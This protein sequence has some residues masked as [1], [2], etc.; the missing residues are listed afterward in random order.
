MALF[1]AVKNTFGL[2]IFLGERKMFKSKNG[3]KIFFGFV[4]AFVITA[5]L[6]VGLSFARSKQPSFAALDPDIEY[7]LQAEE[8]FLNI[9]N[10]VLKGL[11]EAGEQEVAGRHYW[12]VVPS[13]VTSIEG[14][15]EASYFDDKLV[16][17]T[18]SSLTSIGDYAFYN[19][20]SLKEA[21]REGGNLKTIGK[22]AFAGCRSLTTFSIYAS[23][24]VG[25]YAFA[26]CE[27]LTRV[28]F[29]VGLNIKS[30]GNYA[31][32]GCTSL[33]FIELPDSVTSVGEGTFTNCTSLQ[34]AMFTPTD[35]DTFSLGT[36][37]FEG[38]SSLEAIVFGYPT[39]GSEKY[40][41]VKANL[42]KYNLTEYE[43]KITHPVRLEYYERNLADNRLK[44]NASIELKLNNRDIYWVYG[45]YGNLYGGWIKKPDYTLLNA[46]EKGNSYLNSTWS[47]KGQN[48]S[49]TIDQ[50]SQMLINGVSADEDGLYKLKLDEKKSIYYFKDQVTLDWTE[51]DFT[52]QE[53]VAPDPHS[54]NFMTTS[55]YEI[56]L[57]DLPNRY[58]GQPV[59]THITKAGHFYW[60]YFAKEKGSFAADSYFYIE[61][62]IKPADLKN[63]KVEFVNPEDA[64]VTF[65]GR[66]NSVPLKLTY[67]AKTVLGSEEDIPKYTL[68]SEDYLAVFPE[69]D[70]CMPGRKTIKI[71]GQSNGNFIGETELEYT[72]I[73]CELGTEEGQSVLEVS[74]D[75]VYYYTGSYIEPT[76]KNILLRFPYTSYTADIS[77]FNVSYAQYGKPLNAG[78]TKIRLEANPLNNTFC[79]GHFDVEFEVR[80]VSLRSTSI[81]KGEVESFTYDG[82][83]HKP[84]PDIYLDDYQLTAGRDFEYV[85]EGQDFSAAGT[86]SIEIQAKSSNFLDNTFVYFTINKRDI[87]EDLKLSFNQEQES[88]DF[89]SRQITP[90]ISEIYML[91]DGGEHLTLTKGSDCSISFG[92]NIH[93]STGGTITISA[94]ENG[95]YEGTY[96]YSFAI[97]AIDMESVTVEMTGSEEYIYDGLEHSPKFNLKIGSYTVPTA[98]YNLSAVGGSSINV[99]PHPYI[100]DYSYN[101]EDDITGVKNITITI[102]PR[103]ISNK[104]HVEKATITLKDDNLVYTGHAI[105]P[106][107]E[108]VELKLYGSIVPYLTMNEK[109]FTVSYGENIKAG[110]Y[111]EVTIKGT[112]NYTGEY[113]DSFFIDRKDINS[114]DVIITQTDITYDG[115]AHV[116]HPQ[117]SLNDVPFVEDVDYTIECSEKVDAGVY[118]Y[119]IKGG[120]KNGDLG[121]LDNSK[122]LTFEVVQRDIGAGGI[123]VQYV[124][125]E[126]QEYKGYEMQPEMIITIYVDETN[127]ITLNKGT[128]YSVAYD[129]N[130]NVGQASVTITGEGTNFT[131]TAQSHFTITPGTIENA[132]ISMEE[133]SYDGKQ[134][135]I[136]PEVYVGK[137]LLQKDVN[138]TISYEDDMTN[139]GVKNITFT[140]IT[141]DGSNF[142]ESQA[143]RQFKINPFSLSTYGAV[144][145]YLEGGTSFEYTGE[146]ILPTVLRVVAHLGGDDVVI[147][148]QDYKVEYDINVTVGANSV[149]IVGKYDYQSAVTYNCNYVGTYYQTFNITKRN[150]SSG[151]RVTLDSTSYTFTGEQICP[152]ITSF[153]ALDG[154]HLKLDGEKDY[155]LSYGANKDAGRGTVEIRST[156]NGSLTGS[157]TVEFTIE[158]ISVNDLEISELED[159]TYDGYDHKPDDLTVRIGSNTLRKGRDY[160]LNY[161]NDD[162]F[163]CGQKSV[164]VRG[165]SGNITG[166]KTLTFTINKV[167]IEDAVVVELNFEGGSYLAYTGSQVAP[168]VLYISVSLN[169]TRYITFYESEYDVSY[170]E[171]LNVGPATF[172]ITAKP[173]ANF[174]GSYTKELTIYMAN[175][176]LTGNFYIPDFRS[177]EN[178]AE[179]VPVPKFGQATITYDDFD[180]H[181]Y[182][183]SQLRNAN[184]G[185]YRATVRVEGTSNYTEY[186]NTFEFNILD[187]NGNMPG[188][189]GQG[190]NQG[191]GGQGGNQGG[192]QGDN[193]NY[194]GDHHNGGGDNGG[195]IAV[196]VG[197][198]GVITIAGVVTSV[199]LVKKK[200]KKLQK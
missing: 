93:V 146:R 103:D 125:G 188:G 44:T 5:G 149:M 6:F 171:N 54:P 76:I 37:A 104:E 9:D 101:G 48:D 30:I 35:I 111:C 191:G 130:L 141:G 155:T 47:L 161:D 129:N 88:F 120:S 22:Y 43:A 165:R 38:C 64:E 53:I 140:A 195:K 3:L 45:T 69:R 105:E 106:E 79:T 142:R 156:T 50:I 166:E 25:D 199:V 131:G 190:G 97:N 122:T 154:T 192:G 123:N 24:S 173:D 78:K 119:T 77:A 75:K 189:G 177:G 194:G 68:Q 172:T 29:M 175:N 110:K 42:A 39:E 12:L 167:N 92:E 174:T 112:G 2:D 127:T 178:V 176:E 90:A 51:K 186:Y 91:L 134:H 170:G 135:L 10:G 126:S 94:V 17:I 148:P 139:A 96:V 162:Y 85:Y 27:G 180:G 73:P 124:K 20:T 8:K 13:S 33:Q 59:Y 95:N 113:T 152:S 147:D 46:R 128:D 83:E 70:D 21:V 34:S 117:I 49:L 63:V 198:A 133:I 61:F 163:N 118:E 11:S 115:K 60:F 66:I 56:K 184:P 183:F 41:K 16:K 107:V 55:D 151:L 185:H 193:N 26:N 153:E 143:V 132:N 28:G 137:V 181:T 65:D 31:F 109:D 62:E 121:N 164:T 179:P 80:A 99:G 72:I 144:D 168:R 58:Y 15:G 74:F 160:T 7:T 158:A 32:S 52:G 67:D 196:I 36:K 71:T 14:N 87:N 157:Y 81:R 159:L 98:W 23:D 145:V 19:C 89:T 82:K 114:E 136:D 1:L 57:L 169:Y 138:Y 200:K 4:L 187:S 108:S 197:A 86:R 150:I 40:D 100:I 102:K 84:T 182:T 18:Y 116:P